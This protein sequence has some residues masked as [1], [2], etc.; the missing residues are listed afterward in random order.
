MANE[1][2]DKEKNARFMDVVQWLID[3]GK[4]EN[5]GDLTVKAGFG[6]NIIS[7]IKKNHN[8]VSED[9]IRAL[10]EKFPDVN[11]DYIRGGSKYKSRYEAASAQLDDVLQENQAMLDRMK[12]EHP[13]TK[14]QAIDNSFLYEKAIQ[15]V[16]APIY[17]EYID[18]LKKQVA[19]KDDMIAFLKKQLDA[20]EEEINR[21]HA[22]NC[23]LEAENNILKTGDPTKGYLFPYGIAESRDKQ[24]QSRV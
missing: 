11:I 8:T 4:A 14:P 13:D 21:L 2:V 23:E 15:K 16:I 19:D 1:K 6:P 5:Q 17:N 24:D 12:Y 22:R 3:D 7:R 9:T 10:C 18:N 20:K